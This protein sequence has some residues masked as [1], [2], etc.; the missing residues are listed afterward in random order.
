M[1]EKE[2]IDVVTIATESGYHAEIAIYCMNEGKHVIVGKPMAMSIDDA[3]EMIEATKKNNV[4]L[5]V[6]HQN[7]FNKPVQKLREAIEGEKFGRIMNGTARILCRRDDNYYKQSPWRGTW[8]LYG[9][10]SWHR[11]ITVD[12]RIRSWKSLRRMWY[13]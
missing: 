1:L 12:D 13:F 6:V 8:D 7:R 11:L 2:D 3:N 5:S 4:K 10:Y 9:G